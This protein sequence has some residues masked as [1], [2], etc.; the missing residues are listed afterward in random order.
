MSRSAVAQSQTRVEARLRSAAELHACA[1]ADLALAGPR[2]PRG[3][4]RDGTRQP[5]AQ[6]SGRLIRWKEPA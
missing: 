4:T 5:S 6:V 3:L 1:A 2:R